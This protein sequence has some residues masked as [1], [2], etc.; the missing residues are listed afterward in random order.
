MRILLQGELNRLAIELL[1]RMRSLIPTQLEIIEQ[2]LE[3][4]DKA[5]ALFDGVVEET[6]Q[7][8][9]CNILMGF[10]SRQ[11][12]FSFTKHDV[13]QYQ[14]C[15]MAAVQ[16]AQGLLDHPSPKK[17]K[18]LRK[19]IFYEMYLRATV[20]CA[21]NCALTSLGCYSE[22][23]L[24]DI[25]GM[26]AVMVMDYSDSGRRTPIQT[27]EFQH[28]TFTDLYE[29][30]RRF[31]QHCQVKNQSR[32]RA[33]LDKW[34]QF[35]GKEGQPM[36]PE[37]DHVE[38]EGE[39]E[40]KNMTESLMACKKSPILAQAKSKSSADDAFDEGE[41]INAM[42]LVVTDINEAEA[43]EPKAN[44]CNSNDHMSQ[45]DCSVNNNDHIT[46][47][48]LVNK[49][50]K[51]KQD[52][53]GSGEGLI[54]NSASI[55]SK[56][57]VMTREEVERKVLEYTSDVDGLDDFYRNFDQFINIL[58]TPRNSMIDHSGRLSLT[59]VDWT[60]LR[61]SVLFCSMFFCTLMRQ[62]L[63]HSPTNVLFCSQML[64][65]M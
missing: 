48:S 20:Q 32:I 5:V 18:N 12:P 34:K 55:L 10:E 56:S 59:Q 39:E 37:D 22:A 29:Y 65:N 45:D 9:I 16:F 7:D 11:I 46:Q 36:I 64:N 26:H 53:L 30:L 2:Q 3:P 28:T 35:E 62:V 50:D 52:S 42:G 14:V 40:D 8:C 61:N 27:V 4:D 49:D 38:E 13:V 24:K 54:C 47:D 17:R 33:T 19:D 15:F 21:W 58:S 25:I 1:S 60:I 51:R 43:S 57:F 63:F 6:Q 23:D 44:D 41:N 31:I